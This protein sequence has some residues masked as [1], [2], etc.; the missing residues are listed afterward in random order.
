MTSLLTVVVPARI[1]SPLSDICTTETGPSCSGVKPMS[2]YLC[3]VKNIPMKIPQSDIVQ[4]KKFID[5][6]W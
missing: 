5:V 2:Y 1:F 3:K 6:F 4:A